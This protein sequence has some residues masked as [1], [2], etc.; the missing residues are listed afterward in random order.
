MPVRMGTDIGGVQGGVDDDDG[1]LLGLHSLRAVVAAAH[2]S[3]ILIA[4]KERVRA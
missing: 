2:F 1:W 3:P 4:V